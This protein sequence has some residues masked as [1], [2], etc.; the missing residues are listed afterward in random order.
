[1]VAAARAKTPSELAG[2]VRFLEADAAALPLERGSCDLV[3]LV[4]MIPFVDELDRVL[5]PGGTLLVSYSQGPKTPIWVPAA[6][7]RDRLSRL[8]FDRFEEFAAGAG[9]CLLARRG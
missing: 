4:N 6:R 3:V 8:G 2:R 5:A 1:M 9:T 7:L